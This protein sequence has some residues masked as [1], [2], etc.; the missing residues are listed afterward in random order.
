MLRMKLRRVARAAT[1]AVL[2]LATTFVITDAVS[3]K[4][5]YVNASAAA[6]GDGSQGKPLNT[7]LAVQLLTGPGDT[8]IIQPSTAVLNGGL[9]LLP[10]QRLIGD[11]PP[12]VTSA[13]SLIPN[14]PP[15]LQSS[16]Q[17]S[18]PQ[19]TN[20]TNYLL[21]DAIDMA[22]DTVVQNIVI[23]GAFRGGIFAQD[24]HNIAIEGNDISGANTSVQLGFRVQPFCLE[25]YAAGV[26]NCSSGLADGFASIQVDGLSEDSNVVIK[27]NYV[28]DGVCADG[29]NIRAMN[30]SDVNAT[31][32]GNFT[33][34]LVQCAGLNALNNIGTQVLGTARLT[35]ALVGN[36][37][38][39]SGSAG[40]DAE[41]LFI[42]PA[43]AG[44]LI[45]TIENNVYMNGTGGASTNGM[46]FILGNGSP[47]A[48]V[49]VSNSF[50]ANNP[51]DMLEVFNRGARGSKAVLT[52]N[53][54]TVQNTLITGGL[55]SYANPPG[56]AASPD[57]TGECLGV[58]S[59]GDG[60]VTIIEINNSSFT[61]CDNN[62][63]EITNNHSFTDN[64]ADGPHAVSLMI[65]NST[66]S[67]SRFYNLWFN[68][69]TPLTQLNVSVQNSNLSSSQSGIAVA[70]DMQTTGSTAQA[71]IDLGGGPLGSAGGNCIFGGQISNLEATNYNIFAENDYWG[72]ANGPLA[73]S[74]HET[75]PG[76]T[77]ADKQFLRAAP[78][79]CR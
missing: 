5:W 54:V 6:G 9:A 32:E 45:Q 33:T 49:T 48:E 28:H 65:N 72:S 8:I 12:V 31:V 66:I 1:L 16:G 10:G 37:Q 77:I 52:L 36:T 14:G 13:P 50:F 24:S 22:D 29:I 34:R 2:G 67:G 41:A 3:A 69:V 15:T 58:G 56:A 78:P 30:T 11:G 21:G 55:P 68:D 79:A 26:A 40:A 71:T 7:L 76:F 74:V 38:T 57:N 4:T 62:G 23:K 27:N 39:A 43:E 47:Q 59:V 53:N 60:D 73:G 18:L 19:I 63:I 25:Q 46:E 64:G 75:N 51:G 17:S 35:V 44:T 42:N 61:G 20:T 70:F